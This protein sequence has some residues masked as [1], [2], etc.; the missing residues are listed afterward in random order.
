MKGDYLLRVEGTYPEKLLERALQ[1]GASFARVQ[2]EGSR[3]MLLS[4]DPYSADIL[5]KLCK[6]YGIHAKVLR[7]GGLSAFV[8]RAKKRWTICLGL[9][10]CLV[11]SF[12]FLGRIWIV[13]V[14]FTG[15]A[16][17]HGNTDAI[18][19]RVL[20]Y[21]ITT[22]MP[23]A[24]LDTDRLQA[25]LMAE[26]GNYSYIGVR[27]QGIRL[28]VELS[29]E[30]PAPDL[31]RIE[32]PRDLVA[33]RDGVVLGVTVYSG[34]ACVQPGDTV[35]KGQT[36][37]RGEEDKT[38]EETTPVGALGEVTAR[39]WYEGGAETNL[40]T[41]VQVPTGRTQQSCRLRMMRFSLPITECEGFA[42]EK[43]ETESLPVVGMFLPLEMERSI[44]RETRTETLALS[45][46]ELERQL[47]AIAQADALSKLAKD[48]IGFTIADS[49]HETVQNN[50]TLRLRAVYE[51]YTDIATTRDAL[52]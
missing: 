30:V 34:Q 22:G 37:I 6:R 27:R 48:G 10:L 45:P 7:H 32:R 21:G 41:P 8:Q 15:S 23:S 13:D 12:G 52:T 46:G 47:L 18:R 25:Q 38:K 39:C 43:I 40:Q 35:R 11:L 1:Q 29:P 3:T 19:R 9:A 51:V 42:S 16:S 14:C 4:A 26:A 17:S 5:M 44:H 50:N 20:E 33:A 31:Y 49:W 2:R 28:L 24:A 36:L